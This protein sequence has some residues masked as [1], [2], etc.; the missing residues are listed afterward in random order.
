MKCE[1]D[2]L[3]KNEEYSEIND[4]M[5]HPK[6]EVND[7]KKLEQEASYTSERNVNGIFFEM[8]SSVT[9]KKRRKH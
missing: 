2:N 1:T 8:E 6:T 5:I 3:C 7:D 4:L 9:P